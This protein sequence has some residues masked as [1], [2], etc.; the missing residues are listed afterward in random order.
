MLSKPGLP[1]EFTQNMLSERIRLHHFLAALY[2]VSMK[3]K[4]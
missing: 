2:A 3:I 4:V 1:T